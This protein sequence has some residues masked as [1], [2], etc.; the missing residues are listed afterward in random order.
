[1][2]RKSFGEEFDALAAEL[3]RGPGAEM[4]QELE[5]CEL[6]TELGRLRR[7]TMEDVLAVAMHRGDRV[8]VGTRF[9]TVWGGVDYVGS[10]YV[11][12][13]GVD[14]DMSVRLG[15]CTVRVQRSSA[16]GHS[17]SGGSRTFTARLAEYA[18]TGEI[19]TLVLPEV[20]AQLTGQITIVATDHLV[21]VDVGATMT[22]PLDLIDAV[23]RDR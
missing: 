20:S 11:T 14:S 19:V 3:R 12:V 2:T 23:R 16:G 13:V 15:R 5:A 7:R 10:D 18:S 9:G 8:E 1:M 22:V 6:E 17:V 4:F 21:I